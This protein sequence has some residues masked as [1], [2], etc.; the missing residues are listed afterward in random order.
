MLSG[1]YEYGFVP[2]EHGRLIEVVYPEY[3]DIPKLSAVTA[4][5]YALWDEWTPTASL[6]SIA[7]LQRLT[8][9]ARDVTLALFSR[10]AGRQ[11]FVAAAWYAGRNEY[12]RD[13]WKEILAEVP[14]SEQMIFEERGDAVAY[15]EAKLA[16]HARHARP[17]LADVPAPALSR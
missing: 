5:Y 9:D 1:D 4:D 15:L 16:A 10:F 12:A 3:V 14:G 6:G 2:C 7:N 11:N 13:L 8:P 17:D